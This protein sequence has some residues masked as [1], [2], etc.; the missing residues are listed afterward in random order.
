MSQARGNVQLS[1]PQTQVEV[2]PKS[3]GHYERHHYRKE[4]LHSDENIQQMKQLHAQLGS[5]SNTQVLLVLIF[6]STKDRTTLTG[7]IFHF[8]VQPINL[9]SALV[10][11]GTKGRDF[12]GG[13]SVPYLERFL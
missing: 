1:C 9:N 4:K 11:L 3:E 5:A 2:Q 8:V 7:S 10:F 12:C 13:E 6:A